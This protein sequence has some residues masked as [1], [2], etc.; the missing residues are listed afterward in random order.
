MDELPDEQCSRLVSGA[1]EG[2]ARRARIKATDASMNEETGPPATLC[3]Q[4]RSG[5]SEASCVVFFFFF[6]G[7]VRGRAATEQLVW[8]CVAEG[9]LCVR[10][11]PPPKTPPPSR[12]SPTLRATTRPTPP[13]PLPPHVLRYCYDIVTAVAGGGC[14]GNRVMIGGAV[15]C[16]EACWWSWVGGWGWGLGAVNLDCW[17]MGRRSA[18]A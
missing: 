5:F 4:R 14:H 2:R 13:P 12:C 18:G 8:C 7:C 10:F 16:Q 3:R 17:G 15:R 1:S 6:G 11:P 9:Q